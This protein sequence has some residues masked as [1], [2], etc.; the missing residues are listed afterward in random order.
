MAMALSPV[1]CARPFPH[2]MKI[3]PNA[4]I[5]FMLGASLAAPAFAVTADGLR[6]FEGIEEPELRYI[7]A[8]GKFVYDPFVNITDVGDHTVRMTLRYRP[9]WWDSDRDRTDTTR[10]RAE[11]K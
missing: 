11:I 9:D 10:Q 7:V 8:T 4:M 1:P 2:R 6:S 3:F 5:G